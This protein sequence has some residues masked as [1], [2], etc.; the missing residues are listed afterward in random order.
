MLQRIL[1]PILFYSFAAQ[2]QFGGAISEVLSQAADTNI[3]PFADLTIGFTEQLGVDTRSSAGTCPQ[4]RPSIQ[5]CYV[6]TA[7]CVSTQMSPLKGSVHCERTGGS[8]LVMEQKSNGQRLGPYNSFKALG[9]QPNYFV[10][11]DSRPAPLLLDD[12]GKV[13]ADGWTLGCSDFSRKSA[14]VFVCKSASGDVEFKLGDLNELKAAAIKVKDVVKFSG[15]DI[16]ASTIESTDLGKSDSYIYDSKDFKVNG[17]PTM[18]VYK[19]V[20]DRGAHCTMAPKDKVRCTRIIVTEDSRTCTFNG[21]I[22]YTIKQSYSEEQMTSLAKTY[23]FGGKETVSMREVFQK[24]NGVLNP[25]LKTE[26]AMAL[27]K[28]PLI[29]LQG[30]GA[31]SGI[32][33]PSA[34]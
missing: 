11:G 13:I 12:S 23:F 22:R 30:S 21:E 16:C 15:V 20:S 24:T 18:S 33:G 9:G 28:S 5:S 10:A 14:E 17:A 34:Q 26:N 25:Q 31:G 2:A 6:G 32:S 27:F 1:I 4:G 3:R 7:Y 19:G 29:R 8:F